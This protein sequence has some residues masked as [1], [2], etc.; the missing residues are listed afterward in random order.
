[1]AQNGQRTTDFPGFSDLDAVLGNK[2]GTTGS[3]SMAGLVAAVSGR[4]GPAYAT[5]ASLTADLGWAA[6]TLASVWGEAASGANGVYQKT[7]I[8]GAGAWVRIGDLPLAAL[9]AAL[10]AEKASATAVGTLAAQVAALAAG[11]APAG[12]WD[13]TAGAFPSAAVLGTFYITQVA[14]SV[15]G[16]VFAVGDWLIPLADAA[17]T[18]NF[19]P[20]WSRADYSKVV[21]GVYADVVAFVTTTK[22]SVLDLLQD[23]VLT[24][25]GGQ[26]GTVADGDVV[27][28]AD[29]SAPYEVVPSDATLF[30]AQ[31]G[32]GVRL[33]VLQPTDPVPA[34]GLRAALDALE[35]LNAI[36]QEVVIEKRRTDYVEFAVLSCL[37]KAGTDWIRHFSSTRLLPGAA[38]APDYTIGT[39]A[40]LYSGATRPLLGATGTSGITAATPTATVLAAAATRTGTW[41]GPVTQNG[42]A[43]C[44]YTDDA[45][46]FTSTVSYTISVPAG[47]RITVEAPAVYAD[48][49]TARVTVRESGGPEI[50]V[51]TGEYL[52]PRRPGTGVG[53]PTPAQY[54]IDYRDPNG[55]LGVYPVATVISAG[56]YNVKIEYF[57]PYDTGRI[58]DLRVQ[59]WDPIAFDD[60][61]VHGWT[62][63]NS[64]PGQTSDKTLTPG[65]VLVY[66]VPHATGMEFSYWRGTGRGTV[67]FF[68]YDA[69]GA[70]IATYTTKTLDMNGTSGVESVQVAIGLPLGDYFIHVAVVPG[71]STTAGVYSTGIIAIDETVEANPAEDNFDIRDMPTSPGT[72]FG[73]HVLS[74]PG[75]HWYASRWRPADSVAWPAGDN[76]VSGVHGA[77]TALSNADLMV[78]VDGVVVDWDGAAQYTRFTG[79]EIV[80]AYQTT[81]SFPGTATPFATLARKVT[82]IRGG[83]V[84]VETTRTLSADA[85]LSDDY[86]MMLQAP[87]GGDT[88]SAGVGGGFAD[89]AAERSGNFDLGN[90][91]GL[92]TPDDPWSTCVA[93]WNG[94]YCNYVALLNPAEVLRQYRPYLT[95]RNNVLLQDNAAHLA[96]A[97]LRSF[98]G[99]LVTDGIALPAG[100]VSRVVKLYRTLPAPDAGLICAG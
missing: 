80:L 21:A 4:L 70:E 13:A 78:T 62:V 37:G 69:T 50:Y 22:R 51:A 32:G 79:T 53:L 75:N 74:G 67:E 3:L 15:D 73:T 14:G 7:G 28:I 29:G 23:T 91:D 64:D 72:D 76:F 20:G 94:S 52:A 2:D 27:R 48:G 6:G 59:A 93:G 11:L 5:Q 12:A 96:K 68:V 43:D 9:S 65:T 47:G 71:T 25:V 56:S 63:T 61:G 1:M 24:Y 86:I 82:Y 34:R 95:G 84:L 44:Y 92:G 31:T 46:S 38:G 60:V 39:L 36:R 99:D 17:S 77:E 26:V 81:L 42:I 35:P 55:A 16:Q 33:R 19:A 40:L 100:H 18:T 66:A 87:N 88:R 54:M 49:A 97:Y 45:A 57:T 85:I 8:S 10:L 89:W 41:T 30:D 90:S 58:Y 98:G 83:V